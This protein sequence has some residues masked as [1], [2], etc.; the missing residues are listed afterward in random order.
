MTSCKQN[1][2]RNV[3]GMTIELNFRVSWSPPWHL[4]LNRSSL[5]Y[6]ALL[7]CN[8]QYYS[9]L[10]CWSPDVLVSHGEHEEMPHHH[11]FGTTYNFIWSSLHRYARGYSINKQ[12]T[13]WIWWTITG[14][15]KPPA[16]SKTELR[17]VHVKLN[18]NNFCWFIGWWND[19]DDGTLVTTIIPNSKYLVHPCP[20]QLSHSRRTKL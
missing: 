12:K 13:Y 20:F 1:V 8:N 6:N 9:V 10:I 7:K 4:N 5:P 2:Q 18:S 17:C 16:H 15:K 19:D 14:W 11:P 3:W